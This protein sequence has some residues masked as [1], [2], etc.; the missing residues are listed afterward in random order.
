[1]TLYSYTTLKV[2][3]DVI[4]EE[5]HWIKILKENNRGYVCGLIKLFDF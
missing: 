1:M 5:Q 3:I 4:K 2:E